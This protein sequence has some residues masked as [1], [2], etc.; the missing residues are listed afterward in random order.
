MRTSTRWRERLLTYTDAATRAACRDIA[1]P[2]EVQIDDDD[3][4]PEGALPA[5]KAEIVR[6]L[7]AGHPEGRLALSAR[8]GGR[9]DLRGVALPEASLHLADLPAADLRDADLHGASLGKANLRGALLEGVNLRGADLAGALLQ[10]ARLDRKSV[11]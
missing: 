4:L 1:L 6:G 11:V 10:G 5:E 2:E 7:I 8:G 9:V 3:A